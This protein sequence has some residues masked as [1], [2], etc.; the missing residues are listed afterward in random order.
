MEQPEW[1]KNRPNGGWRTAI[2]VVAVVLVVLLLVYL[3]DHVLTT[4]PTDVPWKDGWFLQRDFDWRYFGNWKA[5]L[6]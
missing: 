6:P 5:W 3:L 4:P 1:R 2:A